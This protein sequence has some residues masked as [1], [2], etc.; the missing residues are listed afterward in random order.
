MQSG[1]QALGRMLQ[2]QNWA[3]WRQSKP[4]GGVPQWKAGA[5]EE[6]RQRAQSPPPALL[7][8][9]SLPQLTLDGVCGESR[10]HLL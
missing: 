3:T 7:A 10:R 2:S 4:L 8:L 5:G 6:D 1:L 9:H